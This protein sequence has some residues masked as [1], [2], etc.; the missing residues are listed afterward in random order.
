MRQKLRK[1]ASKIAKNTHFEI[2]YF[3]SFALP[4]IW[5]IGEKFNIHVGA[6]LHLFGL[7]MQTKEQP[8][9]SLTQ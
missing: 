3:P 5:H 8:H 7:A 4:P 1:I 2:Y 6:Q 9:T